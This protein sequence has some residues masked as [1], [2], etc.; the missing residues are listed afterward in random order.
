[1]VIDTNFYMYCLPESWKISTTHLRHFHKNYLE[2]PY[3][4]LADLYS[5]QFWVQIP[6][7]IPGY[8]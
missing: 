7:Y 1:M 2:G 4:T 6:G 3:Y 5:I 8:M